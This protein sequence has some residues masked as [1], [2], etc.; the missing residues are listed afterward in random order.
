MAPKL[1]R[2]TKA[3]WGRRSESAFRIL[4]RSGVVFTDERQ[5]KHQDQE[6]AE[7]AIAKS[8]QPTTLY[9]IFTVSR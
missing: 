6:H 5:V 2:M 8:S 4:V 1:L 7:R 3:R 9:T